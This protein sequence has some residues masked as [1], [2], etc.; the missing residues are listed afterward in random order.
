M[1]LRYRTVTNSK[2]PLALHT[3]ATCLVQPSL[4]RGAGSWRSCCGRDRG[5]RVRQAP[6]TDRQTIISTAITADRAS[7]WYTESFNV[8]ICS[9]ENGATTCVCCLL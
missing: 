4:W 5:V 2:V 8:F 3:C 6:I 7:L 1:G 9:L